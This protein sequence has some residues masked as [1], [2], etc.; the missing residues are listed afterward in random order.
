MQVKERKFRW[1]GRKGIK[2]REDADNGE[3][4]QVKGEPGVSSYCLNA[5][6]EDRKHKGKYVLMY[7]Y[8]F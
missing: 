8:Y 4:R 1:T 3:K 5:L 7:I 2:R 6:K